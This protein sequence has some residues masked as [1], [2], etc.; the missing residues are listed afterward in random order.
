MKVGL[1][2]LPQSGKTTVFQVLAGR[3]D[4]A[5]RDRHG[6]VQMAVVKLP[7]ER[8]QFIANV[9]HSRKV[10]PAEMTFVDTLGLHKGHADMKRAENLTALLGDADAFALVVRCFDVGGNDVG[11]AAQKDLDSLLLELVLT[12]LA[13]LERR[14]NRLEKDLRS[15]KKEAT[16]EYALLSRCREHLEEGRLLRQLDLSENEKR[17]LR[18]FALLTM[19][20]M[21]VVANTGESEIATEPLSAGG[22]LFALQNKSAGMGLATLAFCAALEAELQELD[23]N[24]HSEFM[25]HYGIEE[26]AHDA[27]VRA[28][29]ELL[30]LITFF[31][32]NENETRAWNIAEGT[33]AIE[34]AGKVHTDMARGFIRAEVIAFDDLK[35][36]GTLAECRHR[37]S[38]RLEGKEYIVRDGDILRIRFAL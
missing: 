25:R 36:A 26:L 19:K 34:A 28:C 4:W 32:A 38:A 18:G 30:N 11:D 6:E 3:S 1:F 8:L 27:F 12:D 37:G 33:T 7:D 21:L 5:A 22:K 2:G 9:Y 23:P 13:I 29:F 20:P 16:E 17:A 35:V 14:L 31:T 24:E 10:T 15:G